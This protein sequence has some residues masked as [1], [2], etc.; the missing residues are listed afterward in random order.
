MGRAAIWRVAG[1]L[2][3]RALDR[4]ALDWL[5]IALCQAKDRIDMLWA[6]PVAIDWLPGEANHA[7]NAVF[8][9]LAKRLAR[10]PDITVDP[11]R[12][13]RGGALQA[14]IFVE[15]QTELALDR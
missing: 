2:T 6:R 7:Q 15:E 3:Q 11:V 13:L 10:A 4:V 5:V 12:E 8:G 9:K 1:D 14:P